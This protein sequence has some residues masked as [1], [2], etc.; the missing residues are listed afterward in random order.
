MGGLVLSCVEA[1][2]DGRA[3]SP[4]R[5]SLGNHETEYH[6]CVSAKSQN[7][8]SQPESLGPARAYAGVT[9]IGPYFD[10][11]VGTPGLPSQST[12]RVL[13]LQANCLRQR[14]ISRMQ[15]IPGGKIAG[16][17]ARFD[18]TAIPLATWGSPH[19]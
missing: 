2:G 3:P 19:Q 7:Q 15:I 17:W 12:G 6:E 4:L 8:D 1:G 13:V 10:G 11:S 18:P 9:A 14:A 5:W 16:H